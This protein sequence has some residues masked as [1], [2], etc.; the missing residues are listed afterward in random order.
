MNQSFFI[1][2]LGAH[3]QQ[4][5][6]TVTSN[7]I[8]NVNS[9]GYKGQ[10]ARFS[11]LMYDSLRAIEQDTVGYGVG[12]AVWHTDTNFRAGPVADTGRRMDYAIEGSGF[13]A[14]ADLESGEISYT[15]NG[16]F[17]WGSLQRD[18]GLVDE[19]GQPILEQVYYLSDGEGRMVLGRDGNMIEMG[20]DPHA[21]QDIGVFDFANYNGKE[22]ENGTRFLPVEKNGGITVGSGKVIQGVLEMS[23]VDLANEMVKVIESQRAYSLALKMMTTSDEIETSINNLRG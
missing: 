21:K 23:N 14:L 1:G 17:S 18:S 13:F 12:T 11:H 6:L 10:V 9:H 5:S 2:A 20:E 3:Q 8:A 19:N 4:K 22:H 15:R 16:A 7:N